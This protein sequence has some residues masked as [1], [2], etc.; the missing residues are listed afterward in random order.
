MKTKCYTCKRE[1]T[2]PDEGLHSDET[3]CP[4]HRF[5]RV[6]CHICAMIKSDENK[7]DYW[8]RQQETS[9]ENN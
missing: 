6:N 3:L 4:K 7:A 8:E 5:K 9:N 2:I 1:I